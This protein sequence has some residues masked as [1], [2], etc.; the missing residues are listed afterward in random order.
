VVQCSEAQHLWVL[1][2]LL[3]ICALVVRMLSGA[4]LIGQDSNNNLNFFS[5]SILLLTKKSK[6]AVVEFDECSSISN[7]VLL[8]V[9]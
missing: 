6:S 5:P 3:D 2:S 1:F 8:V 9:L 7:D 4:C